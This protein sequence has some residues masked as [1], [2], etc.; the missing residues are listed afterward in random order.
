MNDIHLSQANSL[1]ARPSTESN[2]SNTKSRRPGRSWESRLARNQRRT[3][4]RS[5]ARMSSNADK[6][7]ANWIMRLGRKIR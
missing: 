5:S 4:S 7:D 2:A 6:Q 1:R 3:R